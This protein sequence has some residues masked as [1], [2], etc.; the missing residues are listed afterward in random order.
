MASLCVHQQWKALHSGITPPGTYCSTGSTFFLPRKEG[1]KQGRRGCRMLRQYLFWLA[2]KINSGSRDPN[3]AHA[4][5]R[6]AFYLPQRLWHVFIY[7][8]PVP[9]LLCYVYL[10]FFKEKKL[11]FILRCRAVIDVTLTSVG[12][13][14]LIEKRPSGRF[15]VWLIHIIYWI[16]FFLLVDIIVSIWFFFIQ[17]FF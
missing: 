5:P 17:F 15:S 8:F 2:A 13:L 14:F 10:F 3:R 1:R 11:L 7:S 16:F 6:F 9:S 12:L 4:R